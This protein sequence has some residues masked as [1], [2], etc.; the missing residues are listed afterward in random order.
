MTPSN[1]TGYSHCRVGLGLCLGKPPDEKSKKSRA[2]IPNVI[3][4][5][6]IDSKEGAFRPLST[7]LKKSTDISRS[8]AN[9]SCVIP[10]SL[11]IDRSFFPNCFRKVPTV[12]VW[13]TGVR[14]NTEQYYGYWILHFPRLR[15]ASLIAHGAHFSRGFL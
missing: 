8:S 15:E 5:A 12:R 14:Y 7:R 6:S 13:L 11:R 9:C 3:E 10:R 2:G 4:K 1:I